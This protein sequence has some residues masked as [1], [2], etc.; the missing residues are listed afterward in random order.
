MT[1]L[2][3]KRTG[4]GDTVIIN[5]SQIVEMHEVFLVGTTITLNAVTSSGG[6]LEVRVRESPAQI[7]AEVGR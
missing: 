5:T 1:F 6:P 3:L 4:S 7:M 2:A